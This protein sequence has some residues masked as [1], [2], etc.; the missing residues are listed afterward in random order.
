LGGASNSTSP[1]RGAEE[2]I[3]PGRAVEHRRL[4]RLYTTSAQCYLL[5]R[6]DDGF[7]YADACLEAI[8]SGRFDE[9]PQED[10]TWLGG[11]YLAK[12]QPEQWVTLCRKMYGHG[13]DSRGYVQACLALAL[14]TAGVNDEALAASRGLLATADATDNPHVASYIL[15]C[16]GIAHRHADPVAAYGVHRRG[17]EIAQ[18]SGNRE[19]ESYHAGNLARLAI[20][21]GEITDGLENVRFAIGV[22]HDSGAY[23]IMSSAH[24]VLTALLVRLGHYESAATLSAGGDA[25]FTSATYPEFTATITHLRHV[26]GD[27]RYESLA[28]IGADM[29]NAARAN[30]ALDLIGRVR[31]DVAQDESP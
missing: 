9:V 23:Q 24:A 17:L 30:Y 27:D 15:L 16:Y 12:N 10:Q 22:W 26:L 7:R 1:S 4:A 2:L 31:V 29:T 14:S 18:R 3:E 19:L 21:H 5:G 6:V 20:N 11:L 8:D 28:R 25:P 13:G